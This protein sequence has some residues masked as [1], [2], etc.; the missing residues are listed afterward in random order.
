MATRQLAR[1]KT[2]DRR[3]RTHRAGRSAAAPV[4]IRDLRS[5]LKPA[6]ATLRKLARYKLEPEIDRLML[7]LGERKESLGKHE[8]DLLLGLVHFWQHRLIESLEARVALQRLRKLAPE[9]VNSQ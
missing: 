6:L 4:S 5:A 7:D 8:H 1:T 3:V 9:L 2:T